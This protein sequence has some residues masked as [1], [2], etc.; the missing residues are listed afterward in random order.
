MRDDPAITPSK[1]Y[2]VDYMANKTAAGP[3]KKMIS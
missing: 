2:C 1:P 3:D